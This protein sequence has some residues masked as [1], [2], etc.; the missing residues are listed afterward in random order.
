M[1]NSGGLEKLNALASKGV[2]VKILIIH[3]HKVD[4]LKQIKTKY[5]EIKFRTSQVEIP[6]LNRITIIDRTKTIV[7][8]IKD[9]TKINSPK[10]TGVTTFIDGESPALSYTA[11]FETLWN[12]TEMF[13]SL[14][15]I[16]KKLQSHD[17]MQKEFLDIIAHELRSPIQPIIGLTEYVKGK[18]KD[19][20]QIELLDSVITSGQKLN[21]LTENILDVSRMEDHLFRLKKE[22]FDLSM[23]I[24]N[25]LKNFNNLFRKK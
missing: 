10:A 12:Q 14:K 15:K 11:V 16:N 24:S 19:K 1:F 3:S 25:T 4:H 9:D 21:T 17:R 22:K 13:D 20:Y 5:P 18:L 7:L 8:K 23:S 2:T 6:I